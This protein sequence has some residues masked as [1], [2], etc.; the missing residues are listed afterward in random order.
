M[1]ASVAVAYLLR[2]PLGLSLA[3]TPENAGLA[4]LTR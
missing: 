2:A 3:E 4:A 1:D